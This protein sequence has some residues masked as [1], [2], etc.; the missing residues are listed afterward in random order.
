MTHADVQSDKSRR[1]TVTKKKNVHVEL[2]I[3]WKKLNKIIIQHQF[4]MY[5]AKS[6]IYFWLSDAKIHILYY[7]ENFFHIEISLKIYKILLKDYPISFHIKIICIFRK[8]I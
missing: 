5:F 8:N 4:I 3:R 6:I 7:C 1:K 2:F